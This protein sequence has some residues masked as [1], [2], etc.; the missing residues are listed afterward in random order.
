MTSGMGLG[1][2]STREHSL[3]QAPPRGHC[4]RRVSFP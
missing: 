4:T 3:M 1:K 2:G